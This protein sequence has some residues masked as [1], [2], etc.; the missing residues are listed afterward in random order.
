M[1]KQTRKET[2]IPEITAQEQEYRDTMADIFFNM[3]G[4]KRWKVKTTQ[5]PVIKG[6]TGM[7]QRLFGGTTG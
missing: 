5:Q 3:F 6:K 1:G 7:T 4:G 2:T